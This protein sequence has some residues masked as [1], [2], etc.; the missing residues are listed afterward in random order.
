MP[1]KGIIAAVNPEWIIGAGGTIPWHYSEDLK[2]FKKLTVGGT[3]IMGRKTWESLGGRPLPH[4]RNV[5][6]TSRELEGVE[7]FPSLQKALTTCDGQDVWFIGGHGI[8]S[9]AMDYADFIDLTYVPDLVD[10]DDRVTFPP[11]DD[12]VFEA[13]PRIQHERDPVLQRQVFTRRMKR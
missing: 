2:R 5:V 3:I 6:I 4:R 7:T 10:A 13:G 12:D 9:E 8:F 11:V 1:R